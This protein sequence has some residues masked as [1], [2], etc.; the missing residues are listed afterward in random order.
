MVCLLELFGFKSISNPE[1]DRVHIK[2][3]KGGLRELGSW[4][5]LRPHNWFDPRPIPSVLYYWRK[6]WGTRS[7]IFA[8]IQT[9]P[10]SLN[11]YWLKGKKSG[12]ILSLVLFFLLL[13]VVV[14]QVVRSWLKAS[15]MMKYGAMIQRI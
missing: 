12:Y 8:L 14:L 10:F 11:P 3:S 13:P 4:D 7:S 6:Y 5:G 9:V 15:K 2:Y 1:A